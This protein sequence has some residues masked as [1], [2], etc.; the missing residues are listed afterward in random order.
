M[1]EE[2][3]TIT[4]EETSTPIGNE[5]EA[6]TEGA[7]MPPVEP[8]PQKKSQKPIIIALVVVLVLALGVIAYLLF[9]NQQSPDQ[10]PASPTTPDTPETTVEEP[11]E[12]V[13]I[14]DQ[15]VTTAL[16]AKLLALHIPKSKSYL[17][18]A[19]NYKEGQ[20]FEFRGGY[21][22]NEHIYPDASELT[23]QDKLYIV[24]S[25]L[26]DHDGFE[27]ISNFD[28]PS[29]YF[30]AKFPTY[31]DNANMDQ[32]CTNNQGY[33]VSEEKVAETYQ[34]F[35]GTTPTFEN[36]TPIC[37]GAAYDSEYHIFHDTV[38]GCGGVDPINHQLYV[39]KYTTKGDLAYIYASLDTIYEDYDP[40]GTT[41]VYR[42]YLENADI[43]DNDT[44]EIIAQDP[45]LLHEE[46]LGVSEY[47][48]YITPE[49]YTFFEQ[50]RFIFQKNDDGN[51]F[52]DSVEKL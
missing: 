13:A 50:Y 46:S 18:Y 17:N 49:N 43:W 51:Y 25:Y 34:S 31:C 9:F 37:G 48:M 33:A 6:P 21:T 3:P 28:V 10:P 27:L 7:P 26:K 19:Q 22:T 52:F 39:S 15:T 24:T 41:S 30:A 44:H 23:N 14:E 2:K 1:D 38:G 45:S 40:S 29:N 36:P 20:T 42:A 8:A 4:P 16:F 47:G 11:V 35:F 5:T 12:E 32:I